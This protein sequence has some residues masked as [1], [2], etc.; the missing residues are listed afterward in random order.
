MAQLRPFRGLRYTL[1]AG[2]LGALLSPPTRT[3][4][5]NEREAFAARTPYSAVNVAAPEGHGDDRSK[6]VRYA[7]SASRIAEW[8]REGIV[9]PEERPALYRLTQRFGSAPLI[10]T[11]LLGVVLP[12]GTV[13]AGEASESKAR[14]D[15]LR[16][17]EATR[18]NFEPAL[19]LYEDADGTL[20]DAVARAVVSGEAVDSLN[21][22]SSVL[23]SIQDP[24]EIARLVEAF[25]S[26]TLT[27]AD[28]MEGYTAAA[29]FPGGGGA[30]VALASFDDPAYA[31]T[32]V[33]RVVRRLPG[34]REAT[35]AALAELFEIE[36][37]HNR[38]L[39][40]HLDRRAEKDRTAFGLATEGGLGYLLIPR[41]PVDVPAALWL[42]NRVLG[43]V[44]GVKETDPTLSFIDPV[45]AIR[46]ADEG[47]AAGFIMPRPSRTDLLDAVR[48]GELLPAGVAQSS[49][50]IPTGLV[51]QAYGDDS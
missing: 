5:P 43:P 50:P 47:A 2:E 39:A 4:T 33:H 16:L 37:H 17:L 6:F 42:Q 26:A 32:A 38:N 14:E 24:D 31:R 20:R 40:I 15:R 34:G 21:A 12:D 11:S 25:R 7:R 29:D 48:L 27:L 36:P 13:R 23:E 45:Q 18:V 46:A 19:A 28:G 49:P 22:A 35:L 41:E 3:L 30:F 9:A 44:L 8:R 1:A 10:R 51:F